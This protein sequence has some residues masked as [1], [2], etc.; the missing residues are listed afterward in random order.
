MNGIDSAIV[1]IN[2]WN[3]CKNIVVE[4]DKQQ[5]DCCQVMENKAKTKA[6]QALQ[7]TCDK[8]SQRAPYL[9]FILYCPFHCRLTENWHIQATATELPVVFNDITAPLIIANAPN[10]VMETTSDITMNAMS[11]SSV[12]N[13][14][15]ET[16]DSQ[17]DNKEQQSPPTSAPTSSTFLGRNS[18]LGVLGVDYLEHELRPTD[19]L[20]GLCLAYNVTPLKLRQANLVLTSDNDTFVLAPKVLAIPIS[21]GFYSRAR[22]TN[23]EHYKLYTLMNKCPKLSKKEAKA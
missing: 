23:S 11:S 9:Q 21:D 6:M 16:K 20:N 10:P 3:R 18:A 19:T 7:E 8:L 4:S 12:V 17:A 13:Q 1:W 14:E 15:T 2:A 22:D 5:H